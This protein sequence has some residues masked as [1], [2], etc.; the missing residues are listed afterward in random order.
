MTLKFFF[1]TLTQKKA[2][3][4]TEVELSRTTV[5]KKGNSKSSPVL[6]ALCYNQEGIIK[7]EN[8]NSEYYYNI[9]ELFFF[10]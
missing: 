10:T 4:T 5:V 7:E 1:E 8:T 2:P 6:T 3:G 9:F